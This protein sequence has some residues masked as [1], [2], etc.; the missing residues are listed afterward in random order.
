[1]IRVVPLSIKKSVFRLALILYLA[2]AYLLLSQPHANAQFGAEEYRSHWE[3]G[4]YH[5]ALKMLEEKMNAD[6][7]QAR[8]WYHRN[9]RMLSDRAELRGIVGLV[10]EAIQD[11][12]EVSRRYEEPAFLLRLAKLYRERGRLV[13]F[14]AT[15]ERA[16]QRDGRWGFNSQEEN[17]LAL[18][19]IAELR[20]E[21]P[22]QILSTLYS[23]LMENYP[24][25]SP[26]Y[27]GA[28]DLALSKRSYDLA[29][30]YY[31]KA[32]EVNEQNQEALSG[33]AECYWKASDPRANDQLEKLLKLN[34]N[35]LQAKALQVET[36]LDRNETEKALKI[37]Q[38]ALDI[39]P[40][41][42][43]FRSLQAAAYFLKD[44]IADVD[45]VQ[46][47]MLEWNPYCSDLYRIPGRVASRHYRFTEAVDFLQKALEVNEEDHE[48][49][50]QLAMDLLRLG[51]DEEGR[52]H[53][54][55]AFK[56]DP[57]NVHVFN[58]LNLMDSL[59][60]F[61]QVVEGPF[62]VQI[63]AQERD[64]WADD[65]MNLLL[66][67]YETYQA[68]YDIELKTPIH[69][70]IFDDHDDFMVR[71]VGLPGQV[72]FLGICFGQLVTMDSP[73]ARTKGGMN[74]RSVLWH[75]FVHVITLQKTNNRMPRWLSEGISVYE[76]TERN[77]AWGQ[78]MEMSY[79]EIIDMDDLPGVEDL[80]L[81][82]TQPKTSSHLM[83]GYFMAGEFVKCY[84]E[85][86]G[87]PAL[88][89]TLRAIG[90]GKE[91]KEAL[92][93]SSGQTLQEVDKAFAGYLEKR[94]AVYANLPEVKSPNSPTGILEQILRKTPA[95]E[96]WLEKESPFTNTLADARVALTEKRWEDA[97]AGLWKAYELYP[98]YQGTE[99]PLQKL[100]ELYER[101]ENHEK[102]KETLWK[103]VE[104]DPTALS[105]VKRLT[106]ILIQD[107][108]WCDAVKAADCGISIDPFDLEL[109]KSI[110][111]GYR[112][113]G[114]FAKALT[115]S[116]QLAALDSAHRT[117]YLLGEIRLYARLEQWPEAKEHTVQLLEEYPHYWDAQE[118]L[119]Q[120]V[121]RSE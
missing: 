63:P 25:F 4:Q 59:K 97:E 28:A 95:V 110:L 76:E 30:K 90:E 107:E 49:R 70:Q 98:D 105:T 8:T 17:V 58:L 64:I 83:L 44:K 116:R 35:S 62:Q 85:T 121:E 13:E 5:E 115:L 71:S 75:E 1:M 54:N 40:K 80:E 114:E 87:F 29:E 65:A 22:K 118:M 48:A 101:Q 102:L 112:Q 39:N 84:V 92:T 42:T 3:Q 36:L 104:T 12:E 94:L 20:G 86:F 2:C 81:Y 78:K 16:V 60:N 32:L 68:K 31:K 24:S 18:A 56:A 37:I 77:S 111:E 96:N 74:W 10:D 119:L 67:A 88:R 73:T 51:R 79:K 26:G 14:E 15:L 69:V 23:L 47:E 91:T 117:D 66:E 9:I 43:R 120:I 113:Q 21:N 52:E 50:A 99:A 6:S 27:V 33:L 7:D 61:T 34:P 46:Q 38:E 103:I 11:L 19:K 82:F 72:G 53:L 57:F 89:E 106:A 45:K 109:R 55:I 41:H 93:E 100:A 108:Q